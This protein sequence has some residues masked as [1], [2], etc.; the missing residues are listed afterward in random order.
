MSELEKRSSDLAEKAS[1]E[2]V[3]ASPTVKLDSHGLPLVP[4]PTDDPSDV[5]RPSVWTC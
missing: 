3:A 5:R 2:H 1:L 4:Q